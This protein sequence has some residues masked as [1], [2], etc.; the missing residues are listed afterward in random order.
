[1]NTWGTGWKPL[2]NLIRTQREQ[3]TTFHP[4]PPILELGGLQCKQLVVLEDA[5]YMF[6]SI[7]HTFLY[8]S[9]WRCYFK[10]EERGG[11]ERGALGLKKH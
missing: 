11:E 9:H 1:M 10:N 2:E 3:K 6:L 7:V 8:T 5:A 4:P